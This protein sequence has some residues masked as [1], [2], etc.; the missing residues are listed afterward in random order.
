[1][2]PRS[3]GPDKLLRADLVM[4]RAKKCP[5]R[6]VLI[7]E[8]V[9]KVVFPRTEESNMGDEFLLF[10]NESCA[11]AFQEEIQKLMI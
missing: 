7:E 3:Y 5:P 6:Q 9:V 4:A 2:I 8:R 11:I 10:Y 1:M